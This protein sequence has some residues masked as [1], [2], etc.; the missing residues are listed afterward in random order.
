MERSQRNGQ[1]LIGDE[2]PVVINRFAKNAPGISVLSFGLFDAGPRYRTT[3]PD[4]DFSWLL[5]LTAAGEGVL[6]GAGGELPIRPHSV[7]VYAEGATQDYGTS[8]QGGAWLFAYVHFRPRTLWAKRVGSWPGPWPGAAVLELQDPVL[9]REAWSSLARA[10]RLAGSP[11]RNHT[12]LALAALEATI[13]WC[14]EANPARGV[15]PDPRVRLAARFARDHAD[16]VVTA[17]DM[18]EA[19]SL[20]ASRLTALFREQMGE[21]PVGYAERLRLE[22]A[23]TLIA[24]SGLTV[25]EAAGAAGY[26]DPYH[27]SRRFTRRMGVPPSA[28]RGEGG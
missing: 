11:Q 10:R 18:A 24:H 13:L 6:R 26:G 27:F 5:M 21:S 19:A 15:V 14:D 1:D 4:G 23:A 8:L 28:W 25:K 17:N 20:S 9:W 22:R 2:R 3:R 12:E 16:Q 7:A